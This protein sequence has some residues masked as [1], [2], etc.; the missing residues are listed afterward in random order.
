[1][2]TVRIPIDFNGFALLMDNLGLSK[3]GSNLMPRF[4][5]CYRFYRSL[6][7]E[8]THLSQ[9]FAG[10]ECIPKQYLFPN[11]LNLFEF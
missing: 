6:V 10:A 2:D 4:R 11:Q 9:V 5:L 8:K 1:M 3:R 7:F